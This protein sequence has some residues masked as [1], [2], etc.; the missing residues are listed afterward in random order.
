MAV[1]FGKARPYAGNK[2]RAAWA[3]FHRLKKEGKIAS[4]LAIRAER[5][6]KAD[7]VVW[8]Y[9]EQGSP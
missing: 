1:P 3:A 5:I 2:A 9:W 7:A 8:I 6:R 4:M